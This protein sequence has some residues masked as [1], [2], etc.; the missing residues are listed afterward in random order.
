MAVSSVHVHVPRTH[1]ALHR[2][3]IG[4]SKDTAGP[5]RYGAASGALSPLRFLPFRAL[6]AFLRLITRSVRKG[7]LRLLGIAICPFALHTGTYTQ[8]L[9]QQLADGRDKAFRPA[10]V[11]VDGVNFS[12]HRKKKT[13]DDQ[14]ELGLWVYGSMGQWPLCSAAR[15]CRYLIITFPIH[16][17]RQMR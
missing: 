4:D 1:C 2:S 13:S 10:T 9:I 15:G 3:V 6:R 5:G 8:D 11:R 17:R 14:L 7:Q 12:P 16:I